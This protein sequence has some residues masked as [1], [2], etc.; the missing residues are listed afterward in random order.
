MTHKNNINSQSDISNKAAEWL[1]GAI[2]G[3]VLLQFSGVNVIGAVAN[4]AFG[5]AGML[6]T[7]LISY[8]T[9]F[10]VIKTLDLTYEVTKSLFKSAF[11][12]D[13]HHD[14]HKSEQKQ[15]TVKTTGDNADLNDEN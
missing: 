6:V 3:V 15:E 5:I 10:I 8:A 13:I 2:V 14:D 4:F 7:P 9:S 11:D 12:H 1:A